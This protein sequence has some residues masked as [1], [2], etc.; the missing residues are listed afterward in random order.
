MD[1]STLIQRPSINSPSTL[2]AGQIQSLLEMTNR[3][4][5]DALSREAR[6]MTLLHCGCTVYFRGIIEFSNIC[7]CDCQYCGIRR[8]NGDVARYQ[9]TQG[10]ILRQA[11][12]CA[13]R[14]FGSVVLQSG[15][16]RDPRFVDFVADVVRAI[17]RE[18][19][20]AILPDGL[21]ITLCVGEQS[22]ESYRRFFDAG[23]HRYLLRI[24][25]S[26]PRLFQR[27][28]PA[29]QTFD[30]RRHCLD[31]LRAIGFQVGTGVMIGAP[32]Q[33]TADLAADVAFFREMDVDMIGMGPYI[34]HHAAPL[35][36]VG[37]DSPAVRLRRT[38]LA[39]A[40]V[41]LVLR[42]VN[43]AA[44]TA[45]QTL[46]P[47]GRERGLAFGA[48]VIMPQVTPASCRKNYTL[49]DAKPC[50]DETDSGYQKALESR[51]RGL[52]RTVGRH[53]WGDSPRVFH[54]KALLRSA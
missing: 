21:G 8:S 52:G 39:I 4:E 6:W 28:H 15:E 42:D 3:D 25:T 50:D 17:K 43:I 9:L 24:E 46:A 53:Q 12:W 2:S 47:L 41:R 7:N 38:L 20:S 37:V 10:E 31:H 19:R 32:W 33:T 1:M 51:I 18:T 22:R 54:R 5:I 48:N 30:N 11:R 16:R 13:D 14:G 49:Y 27:W 23:A 44:T 26:S 35:A 36:A 45:L 29:G 34:P 40:A